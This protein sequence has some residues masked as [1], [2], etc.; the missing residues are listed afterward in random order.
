[1]RVG[2]S[3]RA[4]NCGLVCRQPFRYRRVLASDRARHAL[5]NADSM[6][7]PLIVLTSALV[8]LSGC[9][10][11]Q[12]DPA[13]TSTSTSSSSAT[14]SASAVQGKRYQARGV[15]KGFTEGK[16]AV[17]IAHED[18]PDF[19]KAMTMPFDL[20]SP[21]LVDELKEGDAVDFSFTEESGGRL[22]VQTIKKRQ[23]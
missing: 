21:S 15:I 6:F 8:L 9:N 17:N 14:S 22:L 1:C 7:A 19:M 13:S 18:I 11:N 20:P 10:K 2:A 16:K 4:V 23:P 3:S 5:R 12:T